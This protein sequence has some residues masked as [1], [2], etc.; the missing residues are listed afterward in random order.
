MTSAPKQ[1]FCLANGGALAMVATPIGNLEDVTFRALRTLREADLIAAEDTRRARQLLTHFEISTPVT[2]YHAYNEK[3]KTEQL[4]DMVEAGK[5]IAMLSDAGTPAISDPG[6]LLARAAVAR[7]IEPDVI[8]GVSALTHAAVAAALPLDRFI[9]AG[10]P[11]VKSGKRRRFLEEL[12]AAH[13]TVF[14]FESVHRIGKFLQE[15]VDVLGPET[16]LVVVRE[17]TKLHEQRI[18]GTAASI[19]AATAATKWRGE[20]VIVLDTR[21]STTADPDA[22]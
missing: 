21:E 18:R 20:F 12:G 8:P 11:P 15:I 1:Q 14:V 22:D 16:P 9:F 13:S 10:F 7:G 19:V 6:F 3:W 4:L 5:R 17:A 2:S